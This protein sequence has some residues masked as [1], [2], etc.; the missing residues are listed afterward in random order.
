MTGMSG[1]G[2][3]PQCADEFK[4]LKMDKNIDYIIFNI[5]QNKD[6]NKQEVQ[7]KGSRM[8]DGTPFEEVFKELK[9]KEFDVVKDAGSCCYAVVDAS[10]VK[11]A[12]ENPKNK[13]VF[14]Y[15]GPDTSTIKNKMVYSATKDAII[16]ALGQGI[17]LKC[18]CNDDGDASWDEI[19]KKL[20]ENDK[21]Q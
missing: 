4:K 11:V 10:Y 6:T 18:Q 12:G 13:I 19:K 15:Y 8:K 21:Y 7:V 5:G 3:H 9:T 17:A 20:L 1:I 14:I 16:A 2:V